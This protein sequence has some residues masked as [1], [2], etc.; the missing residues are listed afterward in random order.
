MYNVLSDSIDTL[1]GKY[2]ENTTQMARR[3]YFP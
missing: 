2:Y 3:I 1:T